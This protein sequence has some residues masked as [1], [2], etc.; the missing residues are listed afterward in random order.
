M[1]KLRMMILLI[2]T[3][4]LVGCGEAPEPKLDETFVEETLVEEILIE[5]II[6][7]EEFLE[8]ETSEELL[9]GYCNYS[10]EYIDELYYNSIEYKVSLKEW[11]CY[12]NDGY[13]ENETKYILLR[14]YGIL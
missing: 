1:K 8:E 14:D 13:N 4:L 10:K 5:E 3:C 7:E 6:I 9:K 12:E 2:G 11:R